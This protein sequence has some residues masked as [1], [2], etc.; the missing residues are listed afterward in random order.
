MSEN[1]SEIDSR[2]KKQALIIA[3]VRM[4]N[5]ASDWDI[6]W[7]MAKRMTN[8]QVVEVLAALTLLKGVVRTDHDERARRRLGAA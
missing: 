7:A 2:I 6:A 1:V 3:D 5:A 4:L 8:E